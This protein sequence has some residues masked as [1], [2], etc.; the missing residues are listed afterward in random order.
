MTETI[1]TPQATRRLQ[2][3]LMKITQEP[4]EGIVVAPLPENILIW[5]Y[6][7]LGSPDTPY[8]GGAYHG[9]LIFPAD[10]P[11]KPPAI[12][13]DTP[14]GRF[15][16]GVRLCLSISDY[17]PESWNPGWSVGAI[18]LGLQSF[19]NEETH[20][21]GAIFPALSTNGREK[22]ALDSHKFNNRDQA[23]RRL[24]PQLLDMIGS[25]PGE[26]SASATTKVTRKRN[27]K[28][29]IENDI[30]VIEDDAKIVPVKKV[31]KPTPQVRQAHPALIEVIDLDDD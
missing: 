11:W 26:S 27:K 6:V 15:Q 14:N 1:A 29:P 19:M 13:M 7:L 4:I 24:F 28:R 3:D 10:F 2:K 30:V 25:T 5:H 20:A 23:F 21:A 16:P 17:H 22:L 31:K 9:R 12:Y 8:Q 18:L